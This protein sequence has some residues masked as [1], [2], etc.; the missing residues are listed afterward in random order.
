MSS[1][2]FDA[3]LDKVTEKELNLTLRERIAL[4]FAHISN[5]DK[6]ATAEEKAYW[7]AKWDDKLAPLATRVLNGIMSKEDKVKLDSVD[8]AANHY[9]HPDSII[10]ASGSLGPFLTVTVDKY[11]HIVTGNYPTSLNITVTNALKVNGVDAKNI[12]LLDSPT[13][14]GAPTAPTASSSSYSTQIANTKYVS[15][16]F[17]KKAYVIQSTAPSDTRM[18]WVNS[19]KGSLNY[20]N[21]TDWVPTTAVYSA[22]N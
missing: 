8:E 11:G 17:L 12:A 1:V 18:L 15:D 5:T 13:F 22:S 7:N 20:W 9:V 19:A 14:V 2:V 10:N 16:N 4:A 6:H 21:G 3:Q